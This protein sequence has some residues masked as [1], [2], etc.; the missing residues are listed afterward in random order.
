M[1]NQNG[2][3]PVANAASEHPPLEGEFYSG[4]DMFELEKERIKSSDKRTEIARLAI[5]A[6][7]AADK[8]QFDYHMQKLAHDTTLKAQQN[9]IT[10]NLLYGGGAFIFAVVAL[11]FTMSFFGDEHQSQLAS[12]LLEKLMT[13]LSGI[14]I[15]LLGK[16]AIGKITNPSSE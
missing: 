7:D 1:E 11:L 8:R 4:K 16:S 10:T 12:S 14:G 9:K 5:E 6:N 2:Q 13:A 15:Y 3:Q